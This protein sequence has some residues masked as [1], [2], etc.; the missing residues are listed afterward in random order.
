MRATIPPAKLSNG[1]G[2]APAPHRQ[3]Q[4]TRFWLLLLL[5]LAAGA[6]VGA[7]FLQYKLEELRTSLLDRAKSMTGAELV[8]RAVSVSGL[9]GLTVSDLQVTLRSDEGTTITS[10]VPNVEIYID[11][12]DLL[13]GNVTIERIQMDEAN[14][15]LTRPAGARWIQRNDTSLGVAAGLERFGSFRVLGNHCQLNANNVVGDSE[16]SLQDFTF[17]ISRLSD[18]KHV[19]V[20]LEG[21]LNG[22][23]KSRINVQASFVDTDDFTVRATCSEL[24]A[25]DINVFLPASQH[26]VTTGVTQPNIRIDAYPGSSLVALS[27]NA[28]MQSVALREQPVF[29]NPEAT[30]EVTILANYDLATSILTFL[31]AKAD[32]DQLRGALEGSISFATES[33]VFDLSLEATRFPVEGLVSYALSRRTDTLGEV[34][35]EL[36]EPCS[37][38]V[39][40]QGTSADPK[41]S[42]GIRAAGGTVKFSPSDPNIPNADIRLGASE[43]TWD[44]ETKV[45]K[46]QFTILDGSLSIPRTKLVA[47]R[48][49][50]LGQIHDGSVQF[51]TLNADLVGYP[52]VATLDYHWLKRSGTF[53]LAGGLANIESTPLANAIKGTQLA[54]AVNVQ[55]TGE[56]NPNSIVASGIVDAT[57]A[58]IDYEWWFRKPRG[59][60]AAGKVSVKFDP[61]DRVEIKVSDGEVASSHL[62]AD[63]LM[64]FAKTEWLLQNITAS[65]KRLDLMAVGKCL[66]IPYTVT[67]TAATEGFFRWDR[68]D[69]RKFFVNSSMGCRIADLSAQA[70]GSDSPIVVK[71]GELRVELSRRDDERNGIL[72][73]NTA[74]ASL[75]RLGTSWFQPLEPPAAL[76]ERYQSG[77]RRWTYK[78]TAGNL[79][80][81]PWKG[82]DFKGDGHFGAGSTALEHYS[83]KVDD[84]TIEGSY[85]SRTADNS[86]ETSATWQNVPSSYFIDYLKLPTL[87]AGNMDG[88]VNYSADR[89]DPSSRTGSGSF[90][91]KDGQFSADYLIPW[92]EG[93]VDDSIAVM[94]GWLKFQELS[95]KLAF[96]RDK[97]K[98][99]EIVLQSE[100]FQIK[101]DGQFI[102]D[103]DMDYDLQI[104]LEPEVAQRIESLKTYFNIQGHRLAQQNIN[105]AFHVTGPTFNPRSQLAKSPGASVTLIS[106]ALEVTNE[107]IKVIDLPRR[108][109][110]DLLKVGGGIVRPTS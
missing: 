5:M 31:T 35:V 66:Q 32:S 17:D 6:A 27:L 70:N 93:R 75:P 76:R 90:H 81:P 36:E 50:G 14:I 46:G 37:I 26:F 57:Q 71:N 39:A 49:A 47:K 85:S 7:L 83:A 64:T 72:S 88:E 51:E 4:S 69:N 89:D 53:S 52:C 18:S 78:V 103:G 91:I 45:P 79:D 58:Q 38:Q 40:L 15:E 43:I 65:V 100:G 24:S 11:A 105:L 13:Y 25:D 87:L 48:L 41:F 1:T 86:Y 33:P 97:I 60:G 73:L 104:S 98:T 77:P 107:A 62:E 10:Q 34:A 56:I 95:S 54:G 96:E 21:A 28:P 80:L 19:D 29:L 59:I 42:G 109:L 102:T 30:G 74:K 94:P 55:C 92:I 84:G 68:V 2:L 99:P 8:F 23:P 3:S 9:R 63:L 16:L 82:T 67:G 110:L 61:R 44:P 22:D 20:R 106:G 101:A 12:L 108:L